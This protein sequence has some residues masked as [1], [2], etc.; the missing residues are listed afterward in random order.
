MSII[1]SYSVGNG[2]MFYI[3]HV[4]DTQIRANQT[5][6]KKSKDVIRVK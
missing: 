4:S 6:I 1:K 3:K 5:H 2:D